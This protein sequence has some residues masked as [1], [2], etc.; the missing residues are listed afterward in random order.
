LPVSKNSLYILG[1][2]KKAASYSMGALQRILVVFT[3]LFAVAMGASS[4]AGQNP[5][6]PEP[7]VI[8]YGAYAPQ[9]ATSPV[10]PVSLTWA[11]SSNGQTVEISSLTVVTVG[12]DSF[13]LSRIPF[14]TLAV[15]GGARRDATPGK[16]ELKLAPTTYTRT[17]IVDGKLASLPEAK[18]SFTYGAALQGLVERIDITGA[19]SPE[20]FP[21]WS[22]RIFGR[23]VDGAGDEDN[24]GYTND[25][26]YRAGTAPDDPDSGLAPAA[27][28]ALLGGGFSLDVR[29][30]LGARYQLEKA[31]SPA[32]EASWVPVGGILFGS[33]GVDNF[34][35][36]ADEVGDR[37]FYRVRIVGP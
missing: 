17:P 8:F 23:L 18:R 26:E 5:A 33:G 14:E 7:D 19:P 1:G 31:D 4:A 15:A 2:W 34:L 25:E 20:T 32:E 12:A 3:I 21:N 37:M 11:I 22:N 30:K 10:A 36:P 27:F 28:T 9:G 13:Y 16:L 29:T 24:D 35:I 6:L